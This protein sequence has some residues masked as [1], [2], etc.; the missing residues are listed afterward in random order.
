M[1][2]RKTDKEFRKQVF[3]KFGDKFALLSPYVK[4]T[5][6]VKVK[7]NTCGHIYD[8][9]PNN[10]LN[11]SHCPFCSLN[12]RRTSPQNYAQRVYDLVGDEYTVVTPYKN[13]RTPIVMRHNK[14]DNEYTIRPDRFLNGDRCPYCASNARGTT[15]KFKEK[16]KDKYGDEYQV[17]GVYVD[18]KTPIK[19]RHKVCGYVWEPTPN[20]FLSGRS[21]C[22]KCRNKR[23]SKE[24]RLSI[25]EVKLRINTIYKGKISITSDSYTNGSTVLSYHCNV[26]GF[27]GH[28]VAKNLLGGHGCPKCANQHRND[29]TRFTIN[30]IKKIIKEDTNGEY[31]YI[32]GEYHNN[33]SKIKV[34]HLECGGIFSTTIN[35]FHN[36][37]TT[38]PYCSSSR[39]EQEVLGYLKQHKISHTYAYVI[40][41]LKD[42]RNLHFDFWLPQYNLAIEYDGIQHFVATQFN[43][44]GN[45]QAQ[46]NF[47][48]TQKHDQMKD[49]YCKDHGIALI[50]I[51]YTKTVKSVLNEK[52][53]PLVKLQDN[54]AN[55]TFKPVSFQTIKPLMLNYHY[56]HRIV[57]TSY[58]YGLFVNDQLM[59]MI[60]YT[61]PRVSLAQ[62]ISDQANKDNTLEL[63]RLY[64]KDEVSQTV[65]N[66]T[67]EF[68]SWTLRQLKKQGNW[69][70]I[71]F[72][73][74]GMHHVGAIYQATNFG[75]YGTTN[76]SHR[77]AWNGYGKH[78]GQWIKGHYYR[79]MILSSPKYRYIKAIG[80]KTF[81][82]HAKASI[83]FD[84]QPYPKQDNQHYQI[85]D[86]EERLI[87]DRET[88]QVYRE[89]QLAHK[90]GQL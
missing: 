79:Y 3:D 48:Q 39:G 49:Q 65:P 61:K 31:C 67:S 84:Q 5:Q 56:L 24:K 62:S 36:V 60:A 58:N 33:R 43:Q 32:S 57:T 77:Y 41:G 20:N 2:K 29:G 25:E 21:H 6:K 12:K 76:T 63:S 66:I 44:E 89:T 73:D 13:A 78:G 54:K 46:Q 10:L 45:D 71:S 52:L 4:A 69:F 75:Y 87:Q 17:V 9:R 30:Q 70:I 27:N 53:L 16:V 83:K 81:K 14:C 15:E 42:Q 51:P 74:S 18:V 72:A 88:G 40:P 34:K 35:A 28:K 37:K 50:R 7:N 68:V 1:S 22:P 19:I 86:T 47:K 80:S 38:C 90:L 26:C 8:I 11:G 55:I 23:L 59:G 64:I 82:K 85:G